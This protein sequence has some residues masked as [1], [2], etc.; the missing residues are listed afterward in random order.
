ML[1]YSVLHLLHIVLAF[2][3]NFPRPLPRGQFVLRNGFEVT[4]RY[5]LADAHGFFVVLPT[6]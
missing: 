1:R 2:F 3:L 4:A 6:Q 5:E